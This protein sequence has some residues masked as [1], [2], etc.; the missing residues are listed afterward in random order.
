M[1]ENT[2]SK[3]ASHATKFSGARKSRTSLELL[4]W[5]GQEVPGGP[6]HPDIIYHEI[7]NNIASP[8]WICDPHTLHILDVNNDV[9]ETFGYSVEEAL[10]LKINDISSGIPPYTGEALGELLMKT[11]AE[12]PQFFEWLCRHKDGSLLWAGLNIR[13]TMTTTGGCIIILMRNITRRKRIEEELRK[14]EERYRRLF[15]MELDAIL[16]IETNTQRILDAN[17]AASLLYGYT[18]EDLLRMTTPGVSAEPEKTREA[19]INRTTRIPLRYHRKKDGTVFPVEIVATHL[20]LNDGA[21][22][23]CIAAVRDITERQRAEDALMKSRLY[24]SRIIEFLPDATFVVNT[25]GNIV[26]WNRAMEELTGIPA[27]DVVER[28]NY[29]HLLRPYTDDRPI[30]LGFFIEKDPGSLDV[31]KEYYR[32]VVED[33]DAIFAVVRRD[34]C[35]RGEKTLSAKASP[36]RNDSGEVVGAIE[37]LRDVTEQKKNEQMLRLQALVLDQIKDHVTITDLEGKVTYVNR[38]EADSMGCNKRGQLSNLYRK[39]SYCAGTSGGIIESTL[40]QGSWRGEV[41]AYTDTDYRYTM[42]CRSQVI[43]DETGKPVAL[44]GIAT[45]ITERE[46][47]TRAVRESEARFKEIFDTMEDLYYQVDQNGAVVLVSPSARRLTGWSP[48]ELV[49]RQASTFYA[50]PEDRE[51]LLSMII[52]KGTCMTTRFPS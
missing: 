32:D 28:G 41:T 4:T 12:K 44:C 24:L 2:L 18:K 45:D 1:A 33:G 11:T 10:A 6:E 51:K 25:M 36:I 50:N 15:D 43:Y 29:R 19:T 48:E 13:S 3:H 17:L 46:R 42:D 47:T 37:S 40:E 23:V 39:G 34:F 22:D 38:T 49:G 7:L 27:E 8:I 20:G 16:L 9:A 30:L 5:N 14:S 31:L 52:K 26:I 35:G 21:E